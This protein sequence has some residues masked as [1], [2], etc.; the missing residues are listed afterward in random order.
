MRRKFV[1]AAALLVAALLAVPPLIAAASAPP[2]RTAP[3]NVPTAAPT[4]ATPSNSPSV[5]PPST[6]PTPDPNKLGSNVTDEHGQRLWFG[7]ESPEVAALGAQV[8][9]IWHAN[10]HNIAGTALTSD[11]RAV[12][13][14]LRDLDGPGG[15]E[16]QALKEQAGERLI[17]IPGRRLLQTDTPRISDL[18]AQ[19]GLEIPEMAGLSI[20]ILTDTVEITVDE[21]VAAQLPGGKS[22]GL[23]ELERLLAAQ[24]TP[25]TIVPGAISTFD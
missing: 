18:I 23:A 12:E 13:V 4:V 19:H 20:N 2:G 25:V 8:D 22:P 17:L 14:Y 11:R 16:L 6:L 9:E 5:K 10:M 21:R 1:I 24:D 7:E 15:A 3:G